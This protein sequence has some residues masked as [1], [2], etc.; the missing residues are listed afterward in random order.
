AGPGQPN[1]TDQANN[2]KLLL[3]MT[4]VPDDRRTARFVCAIAVAKNGETQATFRGV[5]AGS[6]LRQPRGDGGFGYDPLFLFAPPNKTFAEITPEEKG[7]VSHRGQAFRKL[8][9]WF[10]DSDTR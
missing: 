3:E 5:V 1:A 8:L 2:A 7:A 9:Q 4:D 6:I 10:L